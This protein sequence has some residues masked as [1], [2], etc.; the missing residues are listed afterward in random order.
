ELLDRRRRRRWGLGLALG[1]VETGGRDAVVHPPTEGR[2]KLVA[3][4]EAL[5]QTLGDPHRVPRDAGHAAEQDGAAC[6]QPAR[7][8]VVAAVVPRDWRI[9]HEPRGG[10]RE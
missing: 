6:G 9:A 5:R 10:R 1:H 7:V 4:G 8:A 2:E 3:E